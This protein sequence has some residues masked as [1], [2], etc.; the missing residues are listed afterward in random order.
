MLYLRGLIA[1]SIMIFLMSFTANL[2]VLLILRI[3][4]GLIGGFQR[5][6]GDR[7]VFVF[8]GKVSL[9]MEFINPP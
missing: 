1:H 9:D 3:C 6:D 5:W 7:L 8:E 2:H 4:Q